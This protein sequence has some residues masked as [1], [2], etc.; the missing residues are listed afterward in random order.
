MD[1][2]DEQFRELIK[3]EEAKRDRHMDPAERWQLIQETITWAE[4]FVRRNTREKCLE[5]Q[6]A[7]LGRTD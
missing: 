4:T 7:K 1:M 6:R 5:L 3:A 2:T